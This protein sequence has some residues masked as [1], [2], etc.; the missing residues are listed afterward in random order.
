MAIHLPLSF[1]A[2]LECRILMMSSNNI[3]HPASGQPIA[4]P[5]QDIVLG[6]YY[7]TAMKTKGKGAGKQFC[8]VDEAVS[9]LEAGGV[10][11]HVPV[12][13]LINGVLIETSVGRAILN[14]VI[15][16]ELGFISIRRPSRRPSTSISVSPATSVPAYSS[17][18]SRKSGS[19]GRP[20][21]A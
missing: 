15:P 2:Q 8:S 1:E 13:I 18:T 14:Q 9:C 10:E 7:L 11:L 3:L 16:K 17:I 5:S 6:C 19:S 20:R 12:K 21:A 4:V